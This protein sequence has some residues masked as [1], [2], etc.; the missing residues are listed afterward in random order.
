M[1]KT[2]KGGHFEIFLTSILLQNFKKLKRDLKN[3]AKKKQKMRIFNS[4]IVPKNLKEG[5]LWDFLT[6]VL[7]QNTKK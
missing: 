5:T 4:L 1:P 7:L 6:F 2:V 3:F